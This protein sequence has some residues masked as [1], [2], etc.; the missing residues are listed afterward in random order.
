MARLRRHDPAGR[1]RGFALDG[2]G[3][4]LRTTPRAARLF[5]VSRH[6][7]DGARVPPLVVR[8][9]VHLG[10][11]TPPEPTPKAEV[12]ERFPRLN[13]GRCEVSDAALAELRTFAERRL[14]DVGL[15]PADLAAFNEFL[16]E[17][18]PLAP[19]EGEAYLR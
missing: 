15:S 1:R 7:R 6:Y 11:A 8:T 13:P 18:T 2:D 5:R 10:E 12:V 4:T 19:F 14:R 17:Q 16:R 9:L 3:W